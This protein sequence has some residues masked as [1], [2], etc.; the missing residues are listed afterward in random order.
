MASK[1]VCRLSAHAI[2][3]E[4]QRCLS[5]IVCRLFGQ[6]IVIECPLSLSGR[7]VARFLCRALKTQAEELQMTLNI[8]AS[9]GCIVVLQSVDGTGL[10]THEDHWLLA[11][12]YANTVTLV[13]VR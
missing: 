2:V 13:K 6:A 11:G 1:F 5:G 7:L 3:I 9:T 10:V 4:C 12:R 8:G